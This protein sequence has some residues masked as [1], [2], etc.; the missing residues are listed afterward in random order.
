MLILVE[1]VQVYTLLSNCAYYPG[2]K[3]GKKHV[4][5]K[6]YALNS[7]LHLLTR[8]LVV[9][10]YKINP[11]MEVNQ[12]S[13]TFQRPLLLCIY[14]YFY[15]GRNNT[16]HACV[17]NNA[18]VCQNNLHPRVLGQDEHAACVLNLADG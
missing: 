11:C 8:V 12:R 16:H 4:L 18:H 13:F 1:N 7:E 10:K 15:I 2:A 6:Q 3:P 9:L 17:A 14:Q 5:N